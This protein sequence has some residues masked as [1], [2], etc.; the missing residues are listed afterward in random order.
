[1]SA[2]SF[3]H[4]DI[5]NVQNTRPVSDRLRDRGSVYPGGSAVY[6]NLNQVGRNQVTILTLT[7]YLQREIMNLRGLSDLFVMAVVACNINKSK[8][9]DGLDPQRFG[10]VECTRPSEAPHG[11]FS[12]D[13]RSAGREIAWRCREAGVA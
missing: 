11:F 12:P 10:P 3:S 2:S 5:F 1:M 4:R 13:F 7:T 9:G 6:S 8:T